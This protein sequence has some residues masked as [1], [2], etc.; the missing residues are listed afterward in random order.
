M[1]N[2]KIFYTNECLSEADASYNSF[3]LDNL[4]TVMEA[5]SNSDLVDVPQMTEYQYVKVFSLF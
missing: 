3:N 1:G 4:C 2:T 5:L